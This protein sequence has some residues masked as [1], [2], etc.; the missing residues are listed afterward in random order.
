M[1]KILNKLKNKLKNS[2][3][4]PGMMM[5][6][7]TVIIIPLALIL[8]SQT[9]EV[10]TQQLKNASIID[11]S[12]LKEPVKKKKQVQNVE[13]SDSLLEVDPV[14]L[15]VNELLDTYKAKNFDDLRFEYTYDLQNDIVGKTI[16]FHAYISDIYKDGR[17]VYIKAL[18]TVMNNNYYLKVKC[19]TAT[20]RILRNNG[21]FSFFV[22]K[23]SGAEKIFI[24]SGSSQRRVRIP[25]PEERVNS[26][27]EKETV[28]ITGKCLASI[29][30]K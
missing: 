5:F 28:L 3:F 13:Q 18:K 16:L 23:V 6:V 14:T 2:S 4:S 21:L 9:P 11:S 24:N 26:I 29:K 19:D 22:V 7:H 12:T 1:K 8:G 17:D 27:P 15:K 30:Q 20:A 25:D 10:E